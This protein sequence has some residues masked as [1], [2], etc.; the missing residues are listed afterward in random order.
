MFVRASE[1]SEI[2]GVGLYL[3]KLAIDKAGGK[4]SLV[5]SSAIGSTFQALFPL[6]LKDIISVRNKNE[7]KLVDLLE[8]PMEPTSNSS[9]V[10]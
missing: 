1:Q 5:Q 6:D 10:S 4:I 9:A 3:I 8:K 7:K 2:G